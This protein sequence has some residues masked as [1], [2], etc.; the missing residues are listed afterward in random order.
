MWGQPACVA[1]QKR[2]FPA[3]AA[4]CL[5]DAA[6]WAA[7]GRHGMWRTCHAQVQEYAL[8]VYAKYQYVSAL[9]LGPYPLT[10][11]SDIGCNW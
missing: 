4:I 9:M 11:F 10:E 8:P 7:R 2:D 1:A 3:C 6:W 5:P